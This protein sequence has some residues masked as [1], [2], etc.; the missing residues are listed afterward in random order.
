MVSPVDPFVVHERM[1]VAPAFV[2]DG[3]AEK[4]DMVGAAVL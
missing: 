3:E 2:L 1:P 4:E